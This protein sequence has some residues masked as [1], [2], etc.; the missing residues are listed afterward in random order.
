MS[1]NDNAMSTYKTNWLVTSFL[2]K[3]SPEMRWAFGEKDE[4]YHQ[5]KDL[6]D[7]GY[8]V[9]IEEVDVPQPQ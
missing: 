5:A 3:D 8:Y 9:K 6:L 1:D 4:A 2:H 7:N